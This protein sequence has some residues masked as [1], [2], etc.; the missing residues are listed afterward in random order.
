[1]KV[2]DAIRLEEE[3]FK[4]RMEIR[5]LKAHDYAKEETD[6]LSNFKVMAAVLRILKEYGYEVDVTTPHGV[7]DF[8]HL[9]K[10]IRRQNLLNQGVEPENEYLEDTYDDEANYLDLGKECYIDE[11]R[12]EGG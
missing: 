11:K 8:L 9:H 5:R 4:R 12:G 2:E 1:M 10:F 6:C 7:A 3:A